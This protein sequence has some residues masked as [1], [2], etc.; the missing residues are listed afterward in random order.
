MEEMEVIDIQR[1]TGFYMRMKEWYLGVA[2]LPL[3]SVDMVG[4]N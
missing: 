4:E 3:T 2:F 1:R